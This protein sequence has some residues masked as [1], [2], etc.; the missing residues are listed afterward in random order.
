MNFGEGAS[1]EKLFVYGTLRTPCNTDAA[2]T[3][4]YE[5]IADEVISAQP[6]TFEG[7]DLLSF[8][9]YPGIK[10]GAGTVVGELFELT[11]AGLEICDGIE[12]HPGFF[13]RTVASVSTG[14]DE[15]TRAWIYWAPTTML[16]DGELIPSG[17]WF[18][19]DR[20]RSDGRTLAEALAEDRQ[21]HV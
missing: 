6:A 2:D 10:P 13:W 3:R 8:I 19:R 14:N 15:K 7:A 16:A 18:D 1:M 17:D 20:G 21:K 4:N 9:H 11:D 12:S 5:F